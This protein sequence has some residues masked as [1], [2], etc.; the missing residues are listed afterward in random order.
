MVF[1]LENFCY[2]IT[3]S[4][5]EAVPQPDWIRLG[6]SPQRRI[7]VTVDV[8]MQPRLRVEDWHGSIAMHLS[9]TKALL[10]VSTT[11]VKTYHAL[12]PLEINMAP[13]VFD[14]R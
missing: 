11:L 1:S 2:E 8:V 4:S 6:I 14:K 7:H 10:H 9:L 13:A 5:R 3:A 12:F